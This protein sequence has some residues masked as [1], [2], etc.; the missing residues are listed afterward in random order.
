MPTRMVKR[1]I[2]A[3]AHGVKWMSSAR[4]K[5]QHALTW[6][7]ADFRAAMKRISKGK[8]GLPS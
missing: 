4:D 6:L 2:N 5:D 3:V 7:S 1:Q 8:A